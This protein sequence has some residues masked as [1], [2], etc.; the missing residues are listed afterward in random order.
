VLDLDTTMAGS[1][2]CDV[3]ELLRSTGTYGPEDAAPE[4]AHVDLELCTAVSEGFRCGAGSLVDLF[5]PHEL[6]WSGPWL[7]VE[8]AVRFLADHLDGD[9][10]FAVDRPGRNLERAQAQLRLADDMVAR[11]RDLTACFGPA[12]VGDR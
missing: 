1:V 10:Y 6:A 4:S 5:G 9:R 2:L 7:T 11:H 12:S 8:N 3:G